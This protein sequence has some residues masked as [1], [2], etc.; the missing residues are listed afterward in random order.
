MNKEG[1]RC[2]VI[3]DPHFKVT[4]MIASSEM[5][6]AIV[7][8]AQEEK[9][10]FIVC[11]GDTLDRHET[12]HT[13]PLTV[14]TKWLANLSEVAK[15]YLLIGN[16]DRP[17]NSDFLSDEHPFVGLRWWDPKRLVVVDKV[18]IETIRDF[19][20]FFVPYV[21]P[22]RF[23]EALETHPEWNP[24]KPWKAGFSHQEFYGSQMAPSI[25]S[26]KG[27]KWPIEYPLL[28][29]GHIH[30]RNIPQKNI[31]CIG[32]P[33]QH[34]FDESFDKALSLFTFSVDS[35]EEKRIP[36]PIPKKIIQHMSAQDFL[37]WEPPS[38][39]LDYLKLEIHGTRAEIIS[40][41]KLDKLKHLRQLGIKVVTRDIEADQ[42]RKKDLPL[43]AQQRQQTSFRDRLAC[44]VKEDPRV[45]KV[46][47][48]LFGQKKKLIIKKK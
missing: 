1:L 2:L 23:I 10:D 5:G 35:Y 47:Q 28:I 13:N 25:L 32:T 11:L 17:N 42:K 26:K 24:E 3:G 22:G 48:R 6:K 36:L 39:L 45:E 41:R 16:H 15:V 46:Y 31:I 19:L 21:P 40:L 18:V 9:P 34:D 30:D 44:R 12:V 37:I 20:F 43:A 38:P 4:E 29:N 7:K 8:I 27:D 14:A 33:R